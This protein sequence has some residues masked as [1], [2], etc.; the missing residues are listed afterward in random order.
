MRFKSKAYWKEQAER[1]ERECISHNDEIRRLSVDLH[2]SW[3]DALRTKSE[4]NA[5]KRFGWRKRAIMQCLVGLSYNEAA[6][7]IASV[8][9]NLGCKSGEEI[10]TYS[11]QS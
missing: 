5:M 3:N 4:L 6:V 7:L 10:I 8:Q 2:K 1:Y 9:G 11:E